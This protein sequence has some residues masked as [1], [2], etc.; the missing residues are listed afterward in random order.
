MTTIDPA[1]GRPLFPPSPATTDQRIVRLR[2][3]LRT[4]EMQVDMLRQIL[5]DAIAIRRAVTD[6][7]RAVCPVCGDVTD[8]SDWG[9]IVEHCS[10]SHRHGGPCRGT[11]IHVDSIDARR[12]GGG[13]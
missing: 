12:I 3:A 8:K 9:T 2:R 5:D 7:A 1:T 4:A 13:L 11:G 10:H 6:P